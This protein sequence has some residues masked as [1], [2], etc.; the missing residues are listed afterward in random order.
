MR[1]KD[2]DILR[3]VQYFQNLW[4]V[5][6]RLLFLLSVKLYLHQRFLISEKCRADTEFYNRLVI[7]AS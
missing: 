1:L 2:I 6:A 5:K 3:Y 4:R 7:T